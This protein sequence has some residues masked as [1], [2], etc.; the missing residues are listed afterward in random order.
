MLQKSSDRFSPDK[1]KLLHQVGGKAALICRAVKQKRRSN[2]TAALKFST[3][4]TRRSVSLQNYEDLY[5]TE[6]PY[7]LVC[8]FET[9]LPASDSSSAALT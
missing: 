2:E 3:K 8:A 9:G 1:T 6:Q 7:G 5:L 4:R